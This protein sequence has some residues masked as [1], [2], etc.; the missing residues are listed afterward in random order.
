MASPT[1]EPTAVPG[2]AALPDAAVVA[3]ACLIASHRL[4]EW[5]SNAPTMEED[6][7]LGNI[8]LDLLGQARGL[9][10][11]LGDED[12]LAYFRDAAEFRNP[13]IC[14]LPNGDFG[15]TVLRSWFIDAW[16]ERVWCAWL[17]AGDEVVRGVA[18]KAIKENAYHRRHSSSWVIRLGDGT[19]ES[20]RR[21]VDALDALWPY[22]GEIA[23]AGWIDTVEPVLAE[24][25]LPVPELPADGRE[26]GSLG[27][28]TE[29]LGA[30]L[31]ES[32]SLARQFPGATW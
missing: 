10:S 31:A 5:V 23:V 29:Y 9:L 4:S 8:A 18:E 28:H 7:A 22:V 26:V 6:V 21:M 27:R 13:T 2:S 20:H 3:D 1:S 30:L 15:H 16:L 32:Q 24:A 25:A 11:H 12:R 14:E 19:D 17:D